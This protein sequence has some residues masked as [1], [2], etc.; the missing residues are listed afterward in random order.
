MRALLVFA[1]LLACACS[2]GAHAGTSSEKAPKAELQVSAFTLD[3]GLE[4]ELVSH[5]SCAG[6]A[7]SLRHSIGADHD[8]AHRSGMARVVASLLGDAVAGRLSTVR[9]STVR[10]SDGE[11]EETL[12]RWAAEMRALP[13]DELDAAK[14][15]VRAALAAMRGGDPTETAIAFAAESVL[16]TLGDGWRGGVAEE[17]DAIDAGNVRARRPAYGPWGARLVIVGPIDPTRMRALVTRTFGDVPA[18]DPPM[19]RDPTHATVT[20]TIVMGDA[21]SVLALAVPAPSSDDAAYPAFAVLAARLARTTDAP[22][23]SRFDPVHEPGILF[24]TAPLAMGEAPD[25]VAASIRADLARAAAAEL[26]DDELADARSRYGAALD[27]RSRDVARCADD[28]RAL[29]EVRAVRFGDPPVVTEDTLRA[30]AG[31]FS[32]RGVAAVAAGG[33]IR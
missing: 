23:T 10:T 24:V 17:I 27:P 5:P 26:S 29:A 21:P 28:P 8:P 32:G 1:L 6:T 11:V 9:S 25:G 16:P 4:V 14:A 12:T 2:G 15:E 13:T 31:R 33:A 3:N 30:A 7:M 22:W 20:G 18:G 19:A